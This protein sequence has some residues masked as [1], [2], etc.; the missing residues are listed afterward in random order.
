DVAS[1]L[2]KLL[3]PFIRHRCCVHPKA[4]D[5]DAVNGFCV[6]GSHR[7]LV[8]TFAV[9]SGAHRELTAGNPD[10]AFRRFAW[11]SRFIGQC[12]FER[13]TTLLR[14]EQL[15]QSQAETDN[16]NKSKNDSAHV[17]LRSLLRCLL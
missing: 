10:H 3:E 13:G 16:C 11:R 2:N 12:W 6:I 17:S 7:H 1:R 4:V 14:V 15:C 5:S 8:T 9:Y